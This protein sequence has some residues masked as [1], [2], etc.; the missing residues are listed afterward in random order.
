MIS[1]DLMR[2]MLIIILFLFRL[3][4]LRFTSIQAQIP[5]DT[6][7]LAGGERGSDF[8]TTSLARVINTK[9]INKLILRSWLSRT[10]GNEESRRSRTLIF[11]V[12][13]QHVKDLCAE[14]REGGVDARYLTGSTLI[15]ER[16]QLLT[17]F[18]EGVFPVL[19]NCGEF[20]SSNRV[21]ERN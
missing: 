10:Q 17:D 5:L 19:V 16:K 8:S 4:P 9:P 15:S 12:N 21:W 6:V 20:K 14:F 7:S 18:G 3:S 13:I 2:M 1:V 11:A